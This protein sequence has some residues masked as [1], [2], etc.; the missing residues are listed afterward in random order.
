M[1]TLRSTTESYP[2]GLT[3]ETL[4]SPA[5]PIEIGCDATHVVSVRLG[6]RAP[7]GSRTSPLARD[8]RR[9]LA[10]Y[11]A[12]KRRLFRLPVKFG[13]SRFSGEVMKRLD[14]IPFGETRS[15]GEIARAVGRPG[16]ARAV[17]QAVGSN[18]LPILIPCHRVLASDGRL[19]GFSAGLSWKRFLLSVEGTRASGA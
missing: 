11:L 7:R 2:G 12:G 17:G 3:F 15:Y 19:G 18:P 16:A 5:G 13:A 14:S 8:A 4:D 10:E 9:Q 6:R 1:K